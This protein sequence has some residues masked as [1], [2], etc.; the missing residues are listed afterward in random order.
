LCVFFLKKILPPSNRSRPPPASQRQKFKLAASRT[1]GVIKLH[2]FIPL[3]FWCFFFLLPASAAL[4]RPR[5]ANNMAAAAPTLKDK[6][7]ATPAAGKASASSRD[8]FFLFI[9]W[10]FLYIYLDC[11]TLI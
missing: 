7:A 6:A 4:P 3:T 11:D 9:D 5:S 1:L 2:V 8:D 10:L